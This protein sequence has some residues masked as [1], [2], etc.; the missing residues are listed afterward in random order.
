[1]S[2]LNSCWS[3]VSIAFAALVLS[4]IWWA[5]IRMVF[6]ESN[7]AGYLRCAILDSYLGPPILFMFMTFGLWPSVYDLRVTVLETGFDLIIDRLWPA[8]DPAYD[9]FIW[10]LLLDLAH[11]PITRIKFETFC[12]KSSRTLLLTSASN[13]SSSF[14][15]MMNQMYCT[16]IKFLIE[17]CSWWPKS[18]ISQ[19]FWLYFGSLCRLSLLNNFAKLSNYGSFRI[20]N[21]TSDFLQLAS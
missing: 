11:G 18:L 3:T 8:S 12:L 19:F 13:S 7:C 1:M 9:L 17:V 10:P 21:S 20:I 14:R 16:N 15:R 2:W 4:E 5:M 6:L